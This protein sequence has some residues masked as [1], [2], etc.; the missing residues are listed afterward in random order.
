MKFET[1]Y[2]IQYI[3]TYLHAKYKPKLQL[4]LSKQKIA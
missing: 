4:I 1:N 2:A 3:L